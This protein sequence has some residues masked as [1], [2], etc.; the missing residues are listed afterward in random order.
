MPVFQSKPFRASG[1]S[2][3]ARDLPSRIA[4][5]YNRKQE[6]NPF[7]YFGLPFISIVVAASFLLTPA[8]ALRY[9][10]HDRKNRQVSDHERMELGLKGGAAGEGGLTYNPRRRK[11]LKGELNERDEYYRLMA[12]DLDN[13]EQK[14]VERWKDEPDGRLR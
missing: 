14:R 3:A 10:K 13:W 11:L 1:S 7:L 12:K 9:E 8:T 5:W 2:A 4:A 6:R